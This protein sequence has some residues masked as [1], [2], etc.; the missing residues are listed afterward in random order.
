MI[1]K[2]RMVLA[3]PG[4]LLTR[5]TVETIQST[6]IQY[7][8]AYDR[9]AALTRGGADITLVVPQQRAVSGPP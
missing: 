3:A 8:E 1:R 4:P 5:L 9:A 7:Y 6:V 2:S